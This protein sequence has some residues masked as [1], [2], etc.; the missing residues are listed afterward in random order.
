MYNLCVLPLGSIL[1]ELKTATKIFIKR[2]TK[3]PKDLP[4]F[5]SQS[6]SISIISDN[7]NHKLNMQPGFPARRRV[8]PEVCYSSVAGLSPCSVT[9]SLQGRSDWMQTTAIFILLGSAI[10]ILQIS[11]A[12]TIIDCKMAT[13]CSWSLPA[14][15]CSHVLQTADVHRLGLLKKALRLVLFCCNNHN[16]A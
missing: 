15:T 4:M 8:F 7:R 12:I 16:K 10:L 3:N 13:L 5:A 11:P 1:K 9:F 6:Q 2:S 14:L